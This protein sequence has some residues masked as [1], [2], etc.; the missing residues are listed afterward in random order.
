MT[1]C[2]ECKELQGEFSKPSSE[3]SSSVVGKVLL[4]VIGATAL[5]LTV[6]TVPFIAP[7]FRKICLP[8]IP[9]TTS[10]VENVLSVLGRKNKLK[11]IDLGSGDGRIVS[12]QMQCSFFS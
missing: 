7:G 3:T 2:E 10:Q 9:A 1:E 4:G 5:G 6:I 12:F 8:Y 11:L